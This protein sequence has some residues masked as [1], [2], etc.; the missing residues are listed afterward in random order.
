MEVHTYSLP[1]L[2]SK[3]VALGVDLDD[4]DDENLAE[5]FDSVENQR[6]VVKFGVTK[7]EV[8]YMRRTGRVTLPATFFKQMLPNKNKK[9][10]K[11]EYATFKVKTVFPHNIILTKDSR[12]MYC[13]DFVEET[14]GNIFAHAYDFMEVSINANCILKYATFF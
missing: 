2:L 10:R 13:V 9:K 4:D 8:K 14:P 5:D 11:L 7:A 3:K 6:S 1:Q 12:I